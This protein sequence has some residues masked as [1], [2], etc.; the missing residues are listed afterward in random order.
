[1]LDGELDHDTLIWRFIL[2]T[3]DILRSLDFKN[4]GVIDVCTEGHR[5][6]S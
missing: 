4:D 6:I 1:M 3:E 2:K 5:N